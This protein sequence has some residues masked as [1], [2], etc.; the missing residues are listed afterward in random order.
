M[1]TKRWPEQAIAWS[2]APSGNAA[3][4]LAAG[5]GANSAAQIIADFHIRPTSLPQALADHTPKTALVL[6]P[7]A[8]EVRL[9]AFLTQ[10]D[11]AAA[12]FAGSREQLVQLVALAPADGA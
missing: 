7:V 9:G 12:D 10:R 1:V 3:S 4:A 2:Q 5:T 8:P 6:A 11:D